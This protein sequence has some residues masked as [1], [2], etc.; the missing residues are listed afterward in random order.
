MNSCPSLR[1]I[2]TD[3]QTG[4]VYS[5]FCVWVWVWFEVGFPWFSKYQLSCQ[6]KKGPVFFQEPRRALIN[7][8][9]VRRGSYVPLARPSR[10]FTLFNKLVQCT[11][12]FILTWYL[13]RIFSVGSFFLVTV[14]PWR[15]LD[16]TWF[17][18]WIYILSCFAMVQRKFVGDGR[19]IILR[20]LLK[21]AELLAIVTDNLSLAIDICLSICL[22]I[23][24]SMHLSFYLPGVMK[25][26]LFELWSWTSVPEQPVTL[27]VYHP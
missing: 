18:H 5:T 7:M 23:Y 19:L 12:W 14:N 21:K 9:S 26:W 10:Q 25:P 4:H 15:F 11:V 3:L 1:L 16:G 8:A 22:S 13:S 17:P 27:V 2:P 24:P 6:Q 20:P